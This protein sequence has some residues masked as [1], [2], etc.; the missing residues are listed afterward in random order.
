[1]KK[2][3]SKSM[4]ILALGAGITSCSQQNEEVQR[5]NILFIM[6]DDH[7]QQAISAYGYDLLHTPNID[8]LAKEG[9]IFKQSFVDLTFRYGWKSQDPEKLITI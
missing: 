2:N 8:R 6:S 5:P 3:L 1:M 7:T 9:A 4:A